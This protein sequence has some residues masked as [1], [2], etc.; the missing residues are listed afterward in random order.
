MLG[1]SLLCILTNFVICSENKHSVRKILAPKG[2]IKFYEDLTA[3]DHSMTLVISTAEKSSGLRYSIKLP[4]GAIDNSNDEDESDDD[5]E[6]ESDVKD[7]PLELVGKELPPYFYKEYSKHIG[8]Y[9]IV[10]VNPTD[11]V[12]KFEIVSRVFKKTNE[13]DQDLVSLRNAISSIKDVGDK[14]ER[15]NNLLRQC[16]YKN[17]KAARSIKSTLRW[18]LILPILN[19]VVG[20]AKY[21][22]TKQIVKPKGKR[23]KG[24]F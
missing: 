8:K 14:I 3:D 22:F 2:E 18:L 4:T 10:I 20:Y 21:V 19:V 7:K 9:V 17:M 11:K 1:L 13:T 24:L 5:Y 12:Q 23:F 16:Q 15:Q 6:D